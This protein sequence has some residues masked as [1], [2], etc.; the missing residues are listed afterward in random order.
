MDL[1]KTS[2][3]NSALL[4]KGINF[5]KIFTHLKDTKEFFKSLSL[6]RKISTFKN[7]EKNRIC[8]ICF[9]VYLKKM[10]TYEHFLEN[11]D[12]PI[13]EIRGLRYDELTPQTRT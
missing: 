13:N 2:S 8:V 1:L 3:V 10:I 5:K 4:Q 6:L 12:C 7:D 9:F 11:R